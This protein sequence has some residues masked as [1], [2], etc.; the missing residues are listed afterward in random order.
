MQNILVL[1]Q[2]NVCRSPMAAGY[3]K[4]RLAKLGVNSIVVSSAGLG[5]LVGCKAT[6]AAREVARR[7]G[8]SIED[9]R[10]RQVTDE[11][12]GAADEV[13]VMTSFQKQ[14]LL[15]HG[16]MPADSIHLLGEFGPAYDPDINDPYGGNLN[17]Y[18]TTFAQIKAAIDGF[19]KEKFAGGVELGGL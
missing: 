15:S 13:L 4:A 16:R 1:C 2:G 14:V 9:H 11:M 18:E 8:F 19:V 3:L 12:L 6:D 7:Q 5:A 17:S 10:A